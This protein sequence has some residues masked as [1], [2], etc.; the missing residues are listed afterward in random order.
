MALGAKGGLAL[1]ILAPFWEP[2]STKSRQKG[3]QKGMQNSMSKKYRKLMPEA[4]QNDT[5]MD[6]KIDEI[7]YFSE[8]GW[9]ARNYLFY[10]R[11]RG[12]GHLKS[13]EKTLQNRC[14]IY[15][16]KRYAKS[17]ENDAKRE[18]KWEPKSVKKR[19]NAGKKACRKW[20]QILIP[21]MTPKWATKVPKVGPRG[22]RRASLRRR[23]F[24]IWLIL[25][26]TPDTGRCRRIV[27][28]G[29]RRHLEILAVEAIIFIHE[30]G[31]HW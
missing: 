30:T 31:G 16:R 8:K 2:F 19:K 18:P 7:S 6:A 4:C 1:G 20:C 22:V 21:K 26:K 11:K 13:H 5:K 9:N 28:R 10:N 29:D 15:A 27:V 3:I 17:M 23:R 14:K 25:L 24:A 12:S